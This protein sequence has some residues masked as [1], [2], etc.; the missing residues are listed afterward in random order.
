MNCSLS[1]WCSGQDALNNSKVEP[2]RAIDSFRQQCR[3]HAEKN[4][5]LSHCHVPEHLSTS[6]RMFEAPPRVSSHHPHWIQPVNLPCRPSRRSRNPRRVPKAFIRFPSDT[7][8][9]R[10]FTVDVLFSFSPLSTKSFLLCIG[11]YH[12]PFRWTMGP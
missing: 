8:L 11:K 4:P 9:S 3:H 12:S 7:V 5:C 1:T 2:E 10:I 6:L